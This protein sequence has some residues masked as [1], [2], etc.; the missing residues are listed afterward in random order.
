[1]EHTPQPPTC[2]VCGCRMP[3]PDL[4]HPYWTVTE[5]DCTGAGGGCCGDAYRYCETD[6]EREEVWGE[7]RWT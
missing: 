2:P 4:E 3:E 1:M 7:E 5:C 6:E